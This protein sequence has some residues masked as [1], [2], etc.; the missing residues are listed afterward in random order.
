M[1]STFILPH[2]ARKF[3]SFIRFNDAYIS[4]HIFQNKHWSSLVIYCYWMIV[5][6]L[7]GR[8]VRTAVCNHTR[9]HEILITLLRPW[10]DSTE[11]LYFK[12]QK[13]RFT[14]NGQ[15][16]SNQIQLYNFFI[17]DLELRQQILFVPT[18]KSMAIQFAVSK[19]KSL[20]VG[21]WIAAWIRLVIALM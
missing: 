10:T 4:V 5:F 20:F 13:S 17:A 16:L 18:K 7:S 8:W 2:S 19:R 3:V 15:F 1:H 9:G 14:N 11:K 21:D 6:V 12:T